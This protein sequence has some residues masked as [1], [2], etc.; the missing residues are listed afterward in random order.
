MGAHAEPRQTTPRHGEQPGSVL[1]NPSVRS[2]E[3]AWP[4]GLSG[5]ANESLLQ[6][7]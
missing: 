4:I 2:G 6:R 7:G 1:R 3:N 5:V